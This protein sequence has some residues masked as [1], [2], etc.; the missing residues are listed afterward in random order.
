MFGVSHLKK[1]CL[2]CK[3]KF[4]NY[5]SNSLI[6]I[7]AVHNKKYLPSVRALNFCRAAYVFC[8]LHYVCKMR[9]NR[10]VFRLINCYH[11]GYKNV[12]FSL[13]LGDPQKNY[14][15]L[16]LNEFRLSQSELT[17]FVNAT[18]FF[19]RFVRAPLH[20]V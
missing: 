9:P 2:L 7:D 3:T 19:Q 8:K 18:E 1:Y 20:S 5:A 11:T 6:L 16:N 13:Q 4:Q 12:R 15:V 14:S 10:I 17:Y